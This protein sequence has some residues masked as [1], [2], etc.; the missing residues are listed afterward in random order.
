MK[1]SD[2]P[3]SATPQQSL[4]LMG[5]PEAIRI[6]TRGSALAR[7]QANWV[8]EQLNAAGVPVEVIFISTQGDVKSGPIGNIGAQGVFTKELQRALL[9]H[10]ID[11][12]VHSLKDLPTDEVDGLTLAAAPPREDCGDALVSNTA[13]SLDE[14]PHG[15]RIGTGSARRSAQL[16]FAREDLDVADIRGNVDTRLKKLDAG[17]YDA[18]ILAEAGLKRLGWSDRIAGVLPKDLMLPAVGQGALGLECRA[19]DRP[20]Q[21]ALARLNDPPTQAAVTAERRLLATLRGGCLAPIGAW[22]R[23]EEGHL[24]LDAVVLD[25]RGRKR[26]SAQGVAAIKDASGLGAE[27]AGRL[28][29]DGAAELIAGSREAD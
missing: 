22:G 7:W 10:Q 27:V 2:A 17:E 26:L 5:E 25:H 21:S 1:E 18:I 15:A 16:L 3:T 11:L 20:T 29:N 8:A 28:L 12:A 13:K 9:D 24:A 23:V 14:L 6:G 4:T 19:D